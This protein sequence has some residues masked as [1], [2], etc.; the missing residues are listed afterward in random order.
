MDNVTQNSVINQLISLL[1]FQ[2]DHRCIFDHY[3]KKLTTAKCIVLF[4]VAL[5]DKWSS[6]KVIEAK[7]RA[8]ENLKRA[9]NLQEISGSQLSR[10]LNEIPTEIF[11]GLFLRLV[12]DLNQQTLGYQGISKRIGKLGIIDSSSLQ[13][14]FSIGDWAR[15]SSKDS[16]VKMHLRLIVASPETVYPD[17]MIPTT[18]N[19]DDREV[20][21]EMITDLDVTYVMDRGYVKYQTMDTWVNNK[22][23]FV[24]RINN[25]HLTTIIEEREIPPGTRISKDAVVL[26]GGSFKSMKEKVRLIEFEDEKG[27]RYRVVTTRY[28][29]S[30][31]EVADIYRHRWLIELYFKWM[32]QH[33]RLVKLFSYKPEAVWNQMFMALI[34]YLLVLKLKGRMNITKSCWEILI[35]LSAHLA[36][37]WTTFMAEVERK[38]TKTSRGRQRIPDPKPSVILPES[39]IGRIKPPK[40]NKKKRSRKVKKK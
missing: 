3:A 11:Q 29:L 5:L 27:R 23:Q 4:T 39:G 24:M 6:Y 17:H 8:N 2:V 10:K 35:L 12:A 22:T 18:R 16:S 20:A 9:L 28:D 30:A 15:L 33:L 32:K 1:P 31:E 19:Y 25:R 38:P 40:E 26:L 14:P 36:K 13:L 7:L 34:G 37:T 21:V